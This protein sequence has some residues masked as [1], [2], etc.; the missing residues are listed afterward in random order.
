M[1]SIMIHSDSRGR[2][3]SARDQGP[4]PT[5]LAFAISDAHAAVRGAWSPLSSEYLFF[6]AKRREATPPTTG[7]SVS[8]MRKA[9]HE[10]G[11]PLESE[12]PYL[13]TLP[14]DWKPPTSVSG[15]YR[16]A[17]ELVGTGFDEAWG[18]ASQGE[19][20]VIV[21]KL[22]DAFY[23]PTPE[24]VVDSAEPPDPNRR[25]AVIAAAA[26]ERAGSRFILVRNSWGMGWGVGGHAWISETYLSSRIICLIAMKEAA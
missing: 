8:S 14:H 24:G 25:H 13:A 16:R 7:A 15:I 20:A 9:A 2:F 11:Q 26:G 17:S 10:D 3:G 1:S 21:M 19:P 5:C 18:I 4:R 22:S 12:C 6:H 23:L